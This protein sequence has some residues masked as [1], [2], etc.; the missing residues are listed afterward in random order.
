[1]VRT[2]LLVR[3]S[4]VMAGRFLW[5][6]ANMGLRRKLAHSG[7]NASG[8]LATEKEGRVRRELRLRTKTLLLLLLR[9]LKEAQG[10]LLNL[11]TVPD[12]LT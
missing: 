6:G 8:S 12:L 5:D 11:R 10:V 2:L 9:P 4:P 7:A 1:M 3:Y